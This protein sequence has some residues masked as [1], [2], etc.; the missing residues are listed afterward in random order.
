MF[1]FT[2]KF[3]SPQK[4][5]LSG[6]PY[7]I[8]ADISGNSRIKINT[9]I[10]IKFKHFNASYNGNLKRIVNSSIQQDGISRAAKIAEFELISNR[11]SEAVNLLISG[12]FGKFNSPK[13]AIENYL[14]SGSTREDN[15]LKLF[16]EYLEEKKT[17][18][19]KSKT[20]SETTRVKKIVKEIVKKNPKHSFDAFD[21]DQSFFG[22]FLTYCR[23]EDFNS[24]TYNK[25]L[26][27]VKAFLN[28]LLQK[29]PNK[30]MSLYYKKVKSF[31]EIKEIFFLTPEEVKALVNHEFKL[32]S[33]SREK[34]LFLFQMA[35]GQR[36]SDIRP[37]FKDF[38]LI[39]EEKNLM[40]V[41]VKKKGTKND[42]FIPPIAMEIYLKYKKYGKFPKKAIQKRNEA[43]KEMFQILNFDRTIQSSHFSM[44]S[45]SLVTSQLK[46]QDIVSTHIAR[47]T[48]IT[49]LTDNGESD[50]NIATFSGHTSNA[51]KRYQGKNPEVKKRIS[52]KINNLFSSELND[53]GQNH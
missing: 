18:G 36:D 24:S 32:E 20:I 41:E 27:G 31:P 8:I 38:S 22:S 1:H 47:S 21:L 16:E 34:D 39:D 43:L 12:E 5:E 51:I 45:L 42:I 40:R 6:S 37:F 3:N 10:K 15:L 49:Y 44:K 35:L 53:L 13:E 30:S 52:V 7:G 19:F 9:G 29:Y 4:A 14:I 33:H 17:K 2:F 50:N 46:V 48:F 25:Y 28:D 23:N 26:K 11:L